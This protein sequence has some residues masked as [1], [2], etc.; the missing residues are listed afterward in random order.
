M[1]MTEH[2]L[3]PRLYIL[4]DGVRKVAQRDRRPASTR[5]LRQGGW[6]VLK[7]I[8]Q[9]LKGRGDRFRQCII[10]AGIQMGTRKPLGDV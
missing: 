1:L 2:V 6:F 5:R 4:W 10:N 7:G 9:M 8:A 3:G